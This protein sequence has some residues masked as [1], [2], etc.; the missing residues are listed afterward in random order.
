MRSRAG[1]VLLVSL[2]VAVWPSPFRAGQGIAFEDVTTRSGIS[3][4]SLPKDNARIKPGVS[5]RGCQSDAFLPHWA[6]GRFGR[7]EWLLAIA[8]EA[9]GALRGK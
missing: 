2:A 7:D 4:D 8:A 3:W 9:A 1:T 6:D 5:Y